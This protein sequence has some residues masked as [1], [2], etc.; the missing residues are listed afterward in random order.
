MFKFLKSFKKVKAK[1]GHET[2][3][4]DKITVTGKD[5]KTKEI[6]LELTNLKPEYCHKCIEKT[7]IR[8]ALCG[9][10]ILPGDLITLVSIKNSNIPKYAVAEGKRFIACSARTCCSN[11]GNLC[12]RWSLPGK[13][14]PLPL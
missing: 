10:Y 6:K 14:T 13:I 4:Y 11:G 12:G 9:E 2:R 8:C 3:L 1:C 7:V 5:D